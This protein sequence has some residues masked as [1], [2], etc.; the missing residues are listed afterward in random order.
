MPLF[1]LRGDNL[2][3]GNEVKEVI[4]RSPQNEEEIAIARTD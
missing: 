2:H 3:A 1:F 4:I